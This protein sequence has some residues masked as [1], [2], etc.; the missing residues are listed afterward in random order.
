MCL[1]RLYLYCPFSTSA[2][3]SFH[4]HCSRNLPPGLSSL[5]VAP[6]KDDSNNNNNN[7]NNNARVM[8]VLVT[9]DNKGVG[10]AICQQ[11]LEKH[12]NISVF[13]GSRN[14]ERRRP[15]ARELQQIL[16]GKTIGCQGRLVVI[17]LD[18]GSDESEAV[19]A[20]RRY[21]N[22]LYGII[23]NAGVKMP[24][25]KSE[26]VSV[27]YFGQRRVDQAFRSVVQNPCGRIIHLASEFSA[28]NFISIC[29][30]MDTFV[31]G[32]SNRGP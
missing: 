8:Y 13:L 15:T 26:S 27:N 24:E 7:N 9:G 23:N 6:R 12:P 16:G 18:V 17:P 20:V 1:W 3:D 2:T 19:V 4:P 29:P 10:K 11:L 32:Y 14:L 5:Q 22:V 25:K 30:P 28:S 31:R 21:T